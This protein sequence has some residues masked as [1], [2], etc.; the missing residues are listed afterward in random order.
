[1]AVLRQRI[2]IERARLK[3]Y[4]FTIS[5]SDG[6]VEDVTGCSAL[7]VARLPGTMPSGSVWTDAGSEVIFTRSTVSGCGLTTSTS[8]LLVEFSK[9]NTASLTLNQSDGGSYIYE[10]AYI[11]TGET[12]PVMVAT[13]ELWITPNYAR[14]I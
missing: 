11:P 9:A 1:M 14:G 7:F 3:R 12:D 4:R 13:G 8:G 2:D 5:G 6:A 10:L